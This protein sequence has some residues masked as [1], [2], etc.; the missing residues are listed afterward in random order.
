VKLTHGLIEFVSSLRDERR[1]NVIVDLNRRHPAPNQI[2]CLA[3]IYV[4]LAFLSDAGWIVCNAVSGAS[5]CKHPWMNTLNS[6]ASQ[7]LTITT[8]GARGYTIRYL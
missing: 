1:P 5:Q 2:P 8:F 4:L 3:D 6:L 7:R